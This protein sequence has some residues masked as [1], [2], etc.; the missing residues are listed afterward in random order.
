MFRRPLSSMSRS[1]KG[2]RAW[3]ASPASC[4]GSGG[5]PGA[6]GGGAASSHQLAS[7]CCC[8]GGRSAHPSTSAHGPKH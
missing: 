5:S 1:C 2:R 8:S 6:G 4:G 7:S 3:T